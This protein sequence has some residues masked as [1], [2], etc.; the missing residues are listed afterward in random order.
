MRKKSITFKLFTVTTAFLLAIITII[1]VLQSS[2]FEKFYISRRTEL[3]KSTVYILKDAYTSESNSLKNTMEIMYEYENSY[4]C[5]AAI[6]TDSGTLALMTDNFEQQRDPS[7]VDVLLTVVHQWQNALKD[8][9]LDSFGKQNRI[10]NVEHPVYRTQSLALV[11]PIISK[12]KIV[13]LAVV[14]SPL[15]PVGEA[16]KVMREYYGYIYIFAILLV[17]LLSIIYSRMVSKPLIRLNGIAERMAHLDFTVKSD[18]KGDDEIGNLS[19]TLNFLSEKLDSSLSKLKDAN[20]QLQKDLDK[21]KQLDLMRKEFIADVSH[22]LK[23]PIS[24]IEGYTEGLLDHV[25][26]NEDRDFYLNVIKD[27]AYKMGLLVSDMLELSRLENSSYELN[28]ECFDI[29]PLLEKAVK[30]H[31]SSAEQL[32]FSLVFSP[33]IPCAVVEGDP[34]R[35]E[36]VLT[37]FLTN[38]LKY[39]STKG[40][41]TLSI[42]E[43]EELYRVCVKNTG[44]PIPKEH[45]EKIWTKFYKVDKSRNREQGGTGLGLAIC[46]NILQLHKSS[47]GVENIENGVSFYFTLKKCNK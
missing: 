7:K 10:Y 2:F 20:E 22:E 38:A 34:F 25:A 44:N 12:D 16:V 29:L 1:L 27:E 5:K 45:L 41:I 39:C 14:V 9:P 36:Q 23:S 31:R 33:E 26:E 17:I 37:N 28:I 19:K 21:E 32:G 40:Q 46:K 24:L 13:G 47:Y 11:S 15:Q 30:K 3:L 42:N 35:L 6:I 4:N 18:I 43:E 8:K